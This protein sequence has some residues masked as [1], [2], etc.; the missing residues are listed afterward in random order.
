MLYLRRVSGESMLPSFRPNQV[1]VAIATK[2]PQISTVVI[3]HHDGMEKIKRIAKIR[4]GE[5]FITGDNPSASTDSRTFGWLSE[6][7]LK[8]VVV[9]PIVK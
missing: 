1:V 8:A 9:W 3:V 5:I 6:T 7:A 2:K 4:P